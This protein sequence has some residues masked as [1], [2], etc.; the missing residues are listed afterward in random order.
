VPVYYS[1]DLVTLYHGDSLEILPTLDVQASALL[2]DPPYFKVKQDAWDN[3]WG[4]ADEFLGWMG[5]WLDAAKPLLASNASAW[6][7]ASPAMTSSVER[8]VGERFRVLSSIRWIKQAGWHQ[9][10]ELAALRSFLSPWEGIV[11]AEQIG[12]DGS[13]LRG[14]GWAD[15]CAKLHAGVFE[16]LRAYMLAER[17]ATGITNRDVD[18]H[19][20]TNG[21]AGHYFGG[22]QWALP[23]ESVFGK[24]R[25]IIPFRREYE[26]LRAEYESLR[27]EYESLR[28]PFAI[29]DRARSTD[30]W[31][32]PT[33]K[34]YKGKHPCEKPAE[35]LGH[36][37]ETS[38]RPGDLILDPF[39]GSGS[40][41][42]AARNLGRRAVGIEQDEHWCEQI[43]LRLSQ[44]RMDIAA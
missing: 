2:T 22:S 21:M 27:A 39:A 9:K 20:G 36:M 32:F 16:P 29:T 34:P 35:M 4:G 7:F 19:L 10:S 11:F 40:T 15:A 13:A 8:V 38:T 3:Q 5:S 18:A 1:D 30:V 42:E 23:T 26:S 6:V 31:D 37:I 25:E 41:L 12:A 14:S 43:A 17:V 44:S 24:L 28:R 33:V